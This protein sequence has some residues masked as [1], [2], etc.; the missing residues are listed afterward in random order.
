MD[1]RMRSLGRVGLRQMTLVKTAIFSVLRH[2]I[3]ETV[4]D[5]ATNYHIAFY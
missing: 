1:N 3:F 2:Y 4:R 5:K